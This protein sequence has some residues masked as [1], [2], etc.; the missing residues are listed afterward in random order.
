MPLLA[1]L[2][3]N[4]TKSTKSWELWAPDPIDAIHNAVNDGSNM[5]SKSNIITMLVSNTFLCKL[6]DSRNA[7]HLFFNIHHR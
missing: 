6:D 1:N 5:G 7:P 2:N 3:E 4:L